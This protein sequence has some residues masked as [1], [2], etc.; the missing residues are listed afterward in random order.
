MTA[1]ERHNSARG[2]RRRPFPDPSELDYWRDRVA[3]VPD[4]RMAKVM[5]VRRALATH[6]YDEEAILEKALATIQH[7][8]GLLCRRDPLDAE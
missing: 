4:L 2:E 3:S 8:V 7:E 1:S 5:R 6:S